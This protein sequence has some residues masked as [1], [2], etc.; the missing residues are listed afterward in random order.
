MISTF[1]RIAFPI[2]GDQGSAAAQRIVS[3]AGY[4]NQTLALGGSA[5]QLLRIADAV[6]PNLQPGQLRTVQQLAG[7]AREASGCRRRCGSRRRPPRS[8]ESRPRTSPA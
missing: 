1:R 6:T 7:D 2:A 4:I 8:T 5:R 3:E